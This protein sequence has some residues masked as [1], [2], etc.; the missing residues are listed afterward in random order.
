M[1]RLTDRP[2]M[3][4]AVDL[5]H[6]A[7]KQTLITKHCSMADFYAAY[8]YFIVHTVNPVL[9]THIEIDKTQVLREYGSSMKVK[10]IAE[11]SLWSILQYF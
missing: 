11:C 8:Q 1:V 6:K 4:I 2:A 9:S 5:G 7:T 3:T 10:S